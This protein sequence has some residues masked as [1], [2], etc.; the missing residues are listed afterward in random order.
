MVDAAFGLSK[1]ISAV[2]LADQEVGSVEAT[3][4]LGGKR[5]DPDTL[6]PLVLSERSHIGGTVKEVR[7]GYFKLSI[8]RHQIEGRKRSYLNRVPFRMG[9][10]V[11]VPVGYGHRLTLWY[12]LLSM[13]DLL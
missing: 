5:V 8:T 13:S 2:C 12:A 4:S 1:Q 10:L 6:R 11:G 7:H 9:G 3:T